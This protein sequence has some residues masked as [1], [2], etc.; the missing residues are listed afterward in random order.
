MDN[1]KRSYFLPAKLVEVFDSEAEKLALEREKAVAAA[2][3]PAIFLPTAVSFCL[4]VSVSSS[5][6]GCDTVKGAW[7]CTCGSHLAWFLSSHCRTRIG[8]ACRPC[9][10]CQRNW[11]S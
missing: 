5:P 8:W 4:W 3:L 9:R 7:F 11:I 2:I 6:S 1:P 10:A